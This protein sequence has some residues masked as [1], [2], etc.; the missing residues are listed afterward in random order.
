MFDILQVDFDNIP[1]GGEM[2]SPILQVSTCCLSLRW[3]IYLSSYVFACSI[4][5]QDAA[6]ESEQFRRSVH[7]SVRIWF[8]AAAH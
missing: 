8:E 1:E 3:Q 4:S 6:V 7:V 2:N 5:L